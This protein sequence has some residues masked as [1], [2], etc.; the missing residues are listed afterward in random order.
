MI[1][2]HLKSALLISIDQ[3]CDDNCDVVLNKEKLYAFKQSKLILEGNR[4]FSDGLWDIPVQKQEIKNRNYALL[5]AYPSIYKNIIHKAQHTTFPKHPKN[6]KNTMH[7]THVDKNN[8][9]DYI[10]HTSLDN[11]LRQQHQQDAK[12]FKKISIYQNSSSLFVIIHKKK[13][14]MELAQYL[15]TACFPQS[16]Q[17]LKKPLK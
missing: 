15:H 1:L 17:H 14:H 10:N 16:A 7:K 3:L 8:H 12:Q 5:V 13:T 2:P 11:T 9:I 4:N 6:P